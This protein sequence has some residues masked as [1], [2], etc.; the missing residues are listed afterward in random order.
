MQYIDSHSH[1]YLEEFNKDR[2]EVIS[3]AL[4]AGVTKIL[5]PNIDKDSI[6]GM[7]EMVND[8]PGI[9]YPMIGVHPCSVKENYKEELSTVI[10]WLT[11]ENFIA[12]GEIGI[13]LYWDKTFL[14]QQI[15]I[16]KSQLDLALLHK[17]PVVI[18]S[19]ESF[20]E[21]FNVLEEYRGSGLKGVFHAFTGDTGEAEFI[22]GLGFKIGIGGIVT[23]KNSGLDKVVKDIGIENL[24]LETDSPYLAPTPYRGKRNESA[25]IPIIAEKIAGLTANS[26]NDVAKVTTSNVLNLFNLKS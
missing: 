20:V 13:D 24:I 21:I 6:S 18:H 2:A 26:I 9:C 14:K 7:L 5:L 25:Y 12:I 1:L 19:R 15:D 17:L 11:K 4:G 22:S 23:F 8:Y 3:R 16:L 10:E